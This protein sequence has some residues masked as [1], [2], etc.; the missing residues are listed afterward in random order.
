MGHVAG[1]LCRLRVRGARSHEVLRQVLRPAILDG[2]TPPSSSPGD[3]AGDAALAQCPLS[4]RG[5]QARKSER[6]ITIVNTDTMSE[7]DGSRGQGVV[8]AV[9]GVGAT[10][11]EES[12]QGRGSD[13]PNLSKGKIR[14]EDAARDN[15]SLWETLETSWSIRSGGSGGRSGEPRHDQIS[16]G[17]VLAINALDPRELPSTLSRN[18]H[19]LLEAPAPA[20]PRSIPSEFRTPGSEPPKTG[21]PSFGGPSFGTESR[22]SE[23]ILGDG[24]AMGKG[25]GDS[26]EAGGGERRGRKKDAPQIAAAAAAAAT[27]A[28]KWHQRFAPVSPLWDP[29]ARALSAALADARPDHVLNEARR[30][31]RHSHAAD[32]DAEWDGSGLATTKV[33]AKGP[34]KGQKVNAEGARV[35]AAGGAGFGAGF[36]DTIGSDGVGGFTP[37]LVVSSPGAATT[38]HEV[39]ASSSGASCGTGRGRGGSARGKREGVERKRRMASSGW[40]LILSAGWAPVFF[41]ALVMA[42]ARAISLGNADGLALETDEPW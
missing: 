31:E 14:F 5:D 22:E 12:P 23:E 32:A 37:V 35:G 10:M 1:G 9:E 34:S 3:S 8:L 36:G 38:A 19:A 6:G 40:D 7:E 39:E 29:D 17:T 20:S 11:S 27:V 24:L 15:A 42:G 25:G 13:P 2:P 4:V 16:A 26:R 41:N 21:P 28:A 33:F 18:R 30:Q